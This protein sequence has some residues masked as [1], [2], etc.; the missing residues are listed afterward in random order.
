M[1]KIISF[2]AI[3]WFLLSSCWFENLTNKDINN[4][5]N[6]IQTDN[7]NTLNIVSGSENEEL[8][9]IIDRFAKEKWYNIKIGFKWSL[10]IFQS[11]NENNQEID[12]VWPASSVWENLLSNPNIKIKHSE[13]IFK[14]PVVFA[15]KK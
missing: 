15:I 1:K 3:F 7:N 10:D 12:A 11:L 6:E 8:Q 4:S 14:T 5:N 13:S 9:Y 2:I